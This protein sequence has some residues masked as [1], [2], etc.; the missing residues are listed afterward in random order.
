MWLNLQYSEY[1]EYSEYSAYLNSGYRCSIVVQP[2]I[3]LYF[4]LVFRNNY[5]MLWCVH[6]RLVR[7]IVRKILHPPGDP[8]LVGNK[9]LCDYDGQQTTSVS[10]H[11]INPF[12]VPRLRG[13]CHW[14]AAVACHSPHTVT[15]AADCLY[16]VCRFPQQEVFLRRNVITSTLCPNTSLTLSDVCTEAANQTSAQ[17]AEAL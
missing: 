11:S 14:S 1:A 4:C 9:L 15:R 2:N 13:L 17:P 12:R 3:F 6:N 7:K 5:A 8:L 10:Y 16:Y